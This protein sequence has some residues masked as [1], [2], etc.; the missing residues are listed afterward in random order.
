MSCSRCI[1]T[2]LFR[3]WSAVA[4]LVLVLGC[5]TVPPAPVTPPEPPPPPPPPPTENTLNILGLDPASPARLQ[6]GERLHVEVA[7]A[8][9]PTTNRV[10][11]LVQPFTA[12][13]RAISYIANPLYRCE[14][15]RGRTRAWISF[16]KDAQ[17]DEVRVNLLDRQAGSFLVTI[18][19]KVEAVW[20][21]GE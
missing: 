3:I 15:V 4:V 11:I 9:V 21:K 12:G 8:L 17:V 5:S 18:T 7:Y 13:K 14:D 16:R 2:D 10:V 19:N 6:P 1:I 20:R